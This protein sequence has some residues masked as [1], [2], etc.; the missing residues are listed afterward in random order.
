MDL[1]G[2][3]AL[4]GGLALFLFGMSLM[5]T[6]LEKSTGN[7][8]KSLLER[9][10]SK[11]LNGF[12]MGVAVTAIIQSSSATTV[13]VVGFVNSGIM[14]LKQAIHII[15][16]ANV[17]TTVTAWILSLA[18]IQGS[19]LFIQ[20]LKPSSFTPI[21]ALIGIIYYMFVKNQKKKDIGLILL[22]F[23]TLIYGMETMSAAVEPLGQME[24]FRN[25]FIAFSNPIIGVLIGALVTGIIQSSSA[26]VGILQALSA[27]GQVTMGAAIPIIMG[28]NI[29]TCVTALISS[30]GAN[31]NARR[32][33]MVH[34]YFNIIGSGVFI[35][36]FTVLNN[37]FSFAFVNKAA[38]HFYIA[39]AHS[40]FNILCTSLLLP[41]SEL[42]EKLAY[43][44]IP[45]DDKQDKVLLLD[46]RL[47]STP[48]IAINRSRVV[49]KEM[50]FT[51][52][53][54]IK[55]AFEL[56]K[57]YDESKAQKVRDA[58]HQTDIYE[59]ALGTYLVKLSSHNLSA[60]DSTEAAKILFLI[61]EFERIADYA[62]N[63]SESAHEMYDKKI[64]FSEQAQKELSV[65][66]AAVD[67]VVEK[68]VKAFTEEDLSLAAK[69]EPLEEVIDDLKSTIKKQ[70]VVRLQCNECT[71]GIG[72]VF[73]D[74][75]TVLERISDHCS[76][77]AGCV[78]EM[79]HDSLNMHD[80]LYKAKHEPNSEFV[81]QYREYSVK[82]ALTRD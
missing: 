48:A 81:Q 40:I 16:G 68:A 34:L 32:A 46:A 9:L 6:G 53:N 25:L 18:G 65:M 42:L 2:F 72:F 39:I 23:A 76:N 63:I 75:L 26:S 4:L 55:Q 28:Q 74:L 69:V 80:Y 52:M 12:L 45:D 44:T 59:D 30:V 27:T 70:H 64:E 1:F 58:E 24:G 19:N 62:M 14:T 61:G 54:A 11:K 41:F 5:G 21:L 17:G 56:I 37:L 57:N 77:I 31:K 35:T 20:L 3:L 82:Y 36:L 79:S 73:S 10:T 22:G 33:A 51:S 47:F 15:M 71:I 7:K 38:N 66:M 60:R 78:I 29:G 50:A 67:E 8:L 49:A 43:K 13:M